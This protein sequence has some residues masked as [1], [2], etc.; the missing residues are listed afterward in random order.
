MNASTFLLSR[1]WYSLIDPF[2]EKARSQ[3]AAVE[4]ISLKYP[5]DHGAVVWGGWIKCEQWWRSEPCW[6]GM[7][8][9]CLLW[10]SASAEGPA[11]H[12]MGWDFCLDASSLGNK[13]LGKKKKRWW[14]WNLSVLV[15]IEN[16]LT[17]GKDRY[18]MRNI[19]TYCCQRSKLVVKW[20]KMLLRAARVTCIYSCIII[21]LRRLMCS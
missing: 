7:A 5:E 11:Q 9:P 17:D 18:W 12:S 16:S 15:T 3:T 19:F 6:A 8:A 4:G 21:I 10:G 1:M 20:K 13:V 14:C 2:G